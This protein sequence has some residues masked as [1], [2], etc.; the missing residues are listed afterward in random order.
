MDIELSTSCVM[1]DI[2]IFLRM[3]FL[4]FS[5][6]AFLPIFVPYGV[7]AVLP[8]VLLGVLVSLMTVDG[9]GW[10]FPELDIQKIVVEKNEQ[11][12]AILVSFCAM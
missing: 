6:G 3:P 10:H 7:F 4:T 12:L 9:K 5:T 11:S 2:V 8:F 1:L